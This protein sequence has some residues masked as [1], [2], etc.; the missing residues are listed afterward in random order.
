MQD[1]YL[2]PEYRRGLLPFKGFIDAICDALAACKVDHV[3]IGERENDERG[4]VGVVYKRLGF[5]SCERIWRK[6]LKK[7]GA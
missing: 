7:E 3:S 5:K 1:I 6:V 4:G 2:A